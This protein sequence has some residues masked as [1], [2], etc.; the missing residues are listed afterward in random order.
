MK[1]T[2][3]GRVHE[4][5]TYLD[6]NQEELA[7]KVGI[8]QP[9]VQRILSG[10]TLNPK[11]IIEISKVLKV[12]PEWLATGD[13]VKVTVKEDA[14]TYEVKRVTQD[15]NSYINTVKVSIIESLKE[16]DAKDLSALQNFL[17]FLKHQQKT[18]EVNH[19]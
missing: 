19:A 9:S 10:K 17:S 3:A 11:K 5:M 8:S 15:E 16:L 12:S 4:R 7:E 6:I 2:L 14:P 18:D 13:D 1:T